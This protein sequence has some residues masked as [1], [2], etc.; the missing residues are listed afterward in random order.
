MTD[1]LEPA[2]NLVVEGLCQAFGD[3][4]VAVVLFGSAAEQRR[5]AVSDTNVAV[6]V[7]CFETTRTDAARSV[8]ALAS[9]ALRMRLLLLR[10]D[11]IADA[12]SAFA[13]KF[14]DIQRRRR[15]LF[16]PDVFAAVVV[17]RS[18]AIAQLHQA[19]LN[20]LMRLR[21]IWLTSR[22]DH[23]LGLS[24]AHLAGGLRACAAELLN[25]EGTA[26]STPREALE[27]IAGTTLPEL[28]AARADTL[29]AAASSGLL[30][31]MVELTE[32]MRQRAA[33]L[34]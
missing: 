5:R 2:L 7:R 9:I 21:E 34:T 29:P 14:S 23:Q 19:L 18:A 33:A 15:V 32:R 6:V 24:I 10:T 4:L 28:S 3:D 13:V 26:V 16:G 27:K 31:R 12:A 11:E 1:P 25:L 30:V 22:D 20:S 17:P 8:V